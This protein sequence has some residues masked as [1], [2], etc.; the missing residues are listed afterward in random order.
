[1]FIRRL[2]G[3][4]ATIALVATMLISLWPPACAAAETASPPASARAPE[5]WIDPGATATGTQFKLSVQAPREAPAQDAVTLDCLIES[6]ENTSQGHLRLEV[7][8]AAGEVIQ[9][10]DLPLRL[11]MGSNPCR[12]V[13][14]TS[15]LPDGKFTVHL[16]L[17][18]LKVHPLTW[19]E[20]SVRKV[21]AEAQQ[22]ALQTAAGKIQQMRQHLAGLTAP[23]TI[24]PHARVRLAIAE[25][26]L[27]VAKELLARDE[28]RAAD[29]LTQY[30]L[31]RS[32]SVRSELSLGAAPTS[33][34]FPWAA[35]DSASLEIRNGGYY[36]QGRPVFLFGFR[37]APELGSDPFHF[38][39]YGANLIPL[40]LDRKPEDSLKEEIG[41]ALQRADHENVAIFGSIAPDLTVD[42]IT[43]LHS[44]DP[45]DREDTERFLR[46]ALT[47]LSGQPRV[48][49]LSLIERPEFRFEGPAVRNAFAAHVQS[50]YLD[51]DLLNRSWK[52]R[53]A[54]MDEIDVW[55]DLDRAAYQYDWQTF[56]QS[57]AS[58]L[59][60]RMDE[61]AH[62]LAPG[63]P[64]GLA[65]RGNAF[66]VG[67]SRRGLDHEALASI[68][69]L[70][71]CVTTVSQTHP[72]YAMA[73]PE[74]YVFYAWLRSLAPES[75]VVNL[76]NHLFN[77]TQ[78]LASNGYDHM[79][80]AMWEA[81]IAGMSASLLW[82]SPPGA[83]ALPSRE[84]LL[85]YPDALEGY[86][87]AG[88]DLNRFAPIVEAFRRSP[89][90]VGIL[91]SKSSKIYADGQPYL[92]S[93]KRAFEGC[94]FAGRAMR[95]VTE[96]QCV[97]GGL[98]GIR[99]LVI[100][101]ALA[102]SDDTFVA[103]DGYVQSGGAVIRTAAPIPYTSRGQSRQDVISHTPRTLL[104]RGTDLPAQYLHAMDAAYTLHFLDEIP[105]AV[106]PYGYPLEAVRTRYVEM[107]GTGYLY[108]LNLRKEPVLCQLVGDRQ[109][110]RDLL[111]DTAVAFPAVLN[112]L[113]PM[114]VRLDAPGSTAETIPTATVSAAPPTPKLKL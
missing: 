89:A 106:N 79:Y 37:S 41:A 94:S 93:A 113:Q 76:E 7:G 29:R 53:F 22:A 38:R 75:P 4:I 63:L 73:S 18:R 61:T 65:Y 23:D 13:W 16:A 97:E 27:A 111:R 81:A 3:H 19:S 68:L 72:D 21:S 58:E 67:E 42:W 96:R 48:A 46:S 83:P 15:A 5:L 66:D 108:V 77:Q 87:I 64:L 8:N 26:V 36:A 40:T 54:T 104:I 84:S 34:E 35:L 55:W 69:G 17:T 107:D 71:G 110:G 91:W 28:W 43:Q 12:F 44:E 78:D 39:R 32:E 30:A 59:I 98:A 9:R 20:L 45:A 24:S 31:G 82:T 88:L 50:M 56:H 14:D 2:N 62:R 90:D 57:L 105:R 70:N 52:T 99:I 74:P 11:T 109:S 47:P 101:E 85:A 95:F 25:D 6:P 51:R 80:S 10:S 1:M 86:A 102:V 92:E 33:Q 103:L 114:L 60:G 100:P 49:G 112:P